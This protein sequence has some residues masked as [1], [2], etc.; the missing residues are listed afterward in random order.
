MTLSLFDV[1]S[2]PVIRKKKNAIFAMLTWHFSGVHRDAS[3]GLHIDDDQSLPFVADCHR[4]SDLVCRLPLAHCEIWKMFCSSLLS[5]NVGWS[6]HVVFDCFALREGFRGSH[7][8][9]LSS[10]GTLILL[11]VKQCSKKTW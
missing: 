2:C 11:A 7:C 8:Y 3:P 5:G 1:L 4:T 10:T 6:E 9:Q